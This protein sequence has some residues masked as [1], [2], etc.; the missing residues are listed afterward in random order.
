MKC[1]AIQL[2]SCDGSCQITIPQASCI[3]G[4]TG[5]VNP[6]S[7][8]ITDGSCTV[9]VQIFPSSTDFS[10]DS[11]LISSFQEHLSNTLRD[12]MLQGDTNSKSENLESLIKNE[13][14]PNWVLPG[15]KALFTSN[16]SQSHSKDAVL[17]QLFPCHSHSTTSHSQP[18]ADWAHLG[19]T[20]S[21]LLQRSF[22]LSSFPEHSIHFSCHLLS[23]THGFNSQHFDVFSLVYNSCMVAA[24][25]AGIP[26]Y[27]PTIA[28]TIYSKDIKHSTK[29]SSEDSIA[30]RGVF[31]FYFQTNTETKKVRVSA[32]SPTPAISSTSQPPVNNSNQSPLFLYRFYSSVEE[33]ID[34][35]TQLSTITHLQTQC[36]Q[37]GLETAQSL[38]DAITDNI[39]SFL[40]GVTTGIH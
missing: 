5:P 23:S 20:I 18:T 34:M 6:L 26:M 13:S 30:F 35:D 38:A 36:I 16:N 37:L 22:D 4:V 11:R 33:D 21:R 8:Q 39:Y 9:V 32:Q 31:P 17:N 25:L 24:L 28:Q 15:Q 40:P 1:S 2:P 3:T 7:K 27:F 10:Q 29:S 14:N 12:I 19:L